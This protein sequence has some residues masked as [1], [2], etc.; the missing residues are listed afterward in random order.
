MKITIRLSKSEEAKALP[1]LY[2]QFAGMVLP[3]RVY[4]LDDAAVAALRKAGIDFEE[5]AA[6]GTAPAIVGARDGERI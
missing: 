1:I 3:Q 6:E 2:R 5:L 4:V